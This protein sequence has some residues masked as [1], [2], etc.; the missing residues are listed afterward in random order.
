MTRLTLCLALLLLAATSHGQSVSIASVPSYGSP[1]NLTGWVS[2]VPNPQAYRVAVYIHIEGSGWWNKP[3]GGVASVP[4]ASNGFFSANVVTGGI[5]DRAT[6]FY[7]ALVPPG[8][9]A[10]SAMG[11]N[12]IPTSLTSVAEDFEERYAREIQ[13]AGRTWGVKD[14]P[15]PVGPGGNFFSAGSQDVFVDGAER[16]TLSSG[17]SGIEISP[18]G[19]KISAPNVE[20][21]GQSSRLK[22]DGSEAQISG[23][24]LSAS[25]ETFMTLSGLIIRLN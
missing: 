14:A 2:G 20:I 7:V 15:I 4:V 9:S 25:A 19:I 6:G 3:G 21:V 22:L 17:D 18:S 23:P 13:F 10:P 12:N 8:G 11:A 5:D 16:I 1:G 24:Q